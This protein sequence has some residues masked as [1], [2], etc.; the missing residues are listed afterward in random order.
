MTERCKT[1]AKRHNE[2][3]KRLNKD[4][5]R[6]LK[7]ITKSKRDHKQTQNKNRDKK[8]S[9]GL[10]MTTKRNTTQTEKNCKENKRELQSLKMTKEKQNANQ[11][12]LTSI[13]FASSTLFFQPMI[14]TW[15]FFKKI[16]YLLLTFTTDQHTH[17]TCLVRGQQGPAELPGLCRGLSLGQ[18]LLGHILTLHVRVEVQL[19][20]SLE[21]DRG[22][23][24]SEHLYKPSLGII[25]N[26]DKDVR[27]AKNCHIPLLPDE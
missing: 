19:V 16:N 22:P 20:E 24:Q 14:T 11:R 10:K 4:E 26:I 25:K 18:P 3:T 8:T 23:R 7:M 9:N 2:T 12:C 27:L 21:E 6:Q 15:R 1:F 17:N 13:K 5:K